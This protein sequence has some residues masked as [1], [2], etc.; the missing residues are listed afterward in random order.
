MRRVLEIQFNEEFHVFVSA[1]QL[2]F[3]HQIIILACSGNDIE[4]QCVLCH[5]VASLLYTMHQSRNLLKEHFFIITR[6]SIS[7]IT[8]CQYMNI[9]FRMFSLFRRRLPHG[10]QSIEFQF[11]TSQLV[12]YS[13][14]NGSSIN[15]CCFI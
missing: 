15:G 6:V 11:D 5:H 4:T 9:K 1:P 3:M 8:P 12:F 2:H 13:I 7:Q 14:I 10:N